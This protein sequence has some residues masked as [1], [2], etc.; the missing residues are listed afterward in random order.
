MSLQI[1][2]KLLKLFLFNIIDQQVVFLGANVEGNITSNSFHMFDPG[3]ISCQGHSSSTI[4]A[5]YNQ[6]DKA[7]NRPTRLSFSLLANAD[8][9]YADFQ[10]VT[11]QTCLAGDSLG[12][13]NC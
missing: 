5:L 12:P 13:S 1:E 2:G 11:P 6:L 3:K 7:V 4:I 9:I 10:L 8:L